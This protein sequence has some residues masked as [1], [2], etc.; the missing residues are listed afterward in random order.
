MIKYIF[1]ALFLCF[2]IA[3]NSQEIKNTF[4]IK[5]QVEGDYSGYIYLRTS[6]MDNIKDSCLV[7]DKKFN[8]FGKLGNSAQA[9]LT[10][11]PTSTVAFFYLENSVIDITVATSVFKNGN[12]DINDI[13]IKKITGSKTQELMN[14]VDAYQKT[15]EKSALSK[16]EKNK[17]IYKKYYELV[18]GNP[19]YPILDLLTTKSKKSGLL[20]VDQL[21]DLSSVVVAKKKI[22]QE[23]DSL[24]IKNDPKISKKLTV[25][26][27]LENFTLPNQTGK[28]ISINDFRGKYVLIDFWASW[29]KP[30]RLN[31]KELVKVYEKYKNK[32]FEILSISI[33]TYAGNW[34][35]AIEKDQLT[36]TNLIE[37]GGWHG[38]VTKQFEIKGIPLNILLDK[39]GK[40]LAVNIK[41]DFLFEKL[42][43][44]LNVNSNK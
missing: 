14:A 2:S 37:T 5:G 30:S 7:A 6:G 23:K 8:F 34:K 25:G 40:I 19:D 24:I 11:K 22:E 26:L 16:E 21:K 36:W 39:D 3:M 15:I 17:K 20:T 10:L 28:K 27:K 13:E 43:H 31:N 4:T 41:G 12:E 44:H 42:D 38:K 32:N 35:T 1:S 33:D 18:I 9:S 29:Y